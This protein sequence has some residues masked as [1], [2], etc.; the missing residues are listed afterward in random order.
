MG[1][2][3]R[4]QLQIT[5]LEAQITRSKCSNA[6]TGEQETQ[7]ANLKHQYKQLE[8]AEK[9]NYERMFSQVVR[10]VISQVR[11]LLKQYAAENGIDI[12]VDESY[13]ESILVESVEDLR[14]ITDDFI[15]YCNKALAEKK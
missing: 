13:R 2:Q 10:P 9:A 8:D 11:A 3:S 4:M 6:S 14:D 15:A 1:V 7:L 12:I 5:D